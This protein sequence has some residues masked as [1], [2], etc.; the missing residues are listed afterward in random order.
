M[1]QFCHAKFN[2]YITAV[3][4]LLRIGKRLWCIRKKCRHLFFGFDKI[5][6]TLVTHTVGVGQFLAGLDTQKDIMRR[7]IICI[8]VMDIVGADQFNAGLLA[9][10]HQLLVDQFLRLDPMALQFQKIIVFSKDGT[11]LKSDLLCLLIH[12]T[13]QI[14]GYHAC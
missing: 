4:D 9:H 10:A 14:T 8:G 7:R 3:S 13:L 12:A 11:V 6:S 2:L 5:L 1:R